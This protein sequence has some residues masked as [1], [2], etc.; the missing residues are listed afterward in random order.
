MYPDIFVV[1][2]NGAFTELT[3]SSSTAPVELNAR[4]HLFSLSGDHFIMK[5]TLDDAASTTT[6]D[7]AFTIHYTDPCQ[8]ATIEPWSTTYISA[9]WREEPD[10]I[11]IW[12]FPAFRDSVDT[13]ASLDYAEG[14]CGP[15]VP[16]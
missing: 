2:V 6:I 16:I 5:G 12:T 7:Q 1:D 8:S 15:K 9:I 13:D 10:D 11:K 4:K 3:L 14:I